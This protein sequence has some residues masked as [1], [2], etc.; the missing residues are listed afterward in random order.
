MK[1]F[2]IGVQEK[3]A[4]LFNEWE[5]FTSTDGDMDVLAAVGEGGRRRQLEASD[6]WP[7]SGRIE[8]EAPGKFLRREECDKL[9]TPKLDND[10]NMKQDVDVLAAVGE[11]GRR[12]R[13]EVNNMWPESGPMEEEAPENSLEREEV[14]CYN[15]RGMSHLVR[16]CTVRPRRRMLIIS[17]LR[18]LDEIEEVNANCILMANLQQA[19]T[20]EA[21]ES[22]AKHKALEYDIDRLLRAVVSQD[23]MSIVHSNSVVDTSNLQTEL[24]RTKEKLK[25]CIIKKEKEYAVL[26]NNWSKKVVELNALSK[27]V[28]SNSAHFTREPKVVNNDRVISPRMFR[29]NLSNTSRVD[30]VMPNKPVKASVKTKPITVSQSYVI[31]KK[32]VNSV[33]NG[34]SRTRVNNTA[35]TRRP[36]PKSNTKNNR[37]PSA[38]KSSCIKNKEVKVEKHNKNLLLSKNKKHMSSESNNI[39]LAI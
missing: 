23:I 12:R 6:R 26:G 1:G 22:L 38:S 36:Q 28:T 18:D 29:I 5:R 7:E 21:N 31:T 33:S 24:D 35:Q 39:K 20:S 11:E 9:M 19:S 25:T 32:D 3:K 37:V 14:R 16:N 10:C 4:K 34:L 17:R 27:P 2:D 13:L 15:R 30:N 8:E